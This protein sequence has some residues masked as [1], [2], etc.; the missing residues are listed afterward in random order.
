MSA[1]A[2]MVQGTASH[3]GKSVLVTVLCGILYQD[4]F[5]GAPFK[6]HNMSLNSFVTVGGGE[7]G[8]A[9]TV[10]ADAAGDHV[11]DLEYDR[12]TALVRGSLRMDLSYQMARHEV[13]PS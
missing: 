13:S 7:I 1:R 8:R 12:L 9:R 10:Q 5:R 4:G 6:A 2:L 11:Q 3:V